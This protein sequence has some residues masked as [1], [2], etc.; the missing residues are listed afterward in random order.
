MV[1]KRRIY[2]WLLNQMQFK[3]SGCLHF[4]SNKLI[5]RGFLSVS[6]KVSSPTF[7]LSFFLLSEEF[8]DTCISRYFLIVQQNWDAQ[9]L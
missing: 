9:M 4:I 2:F 5:A 7:T 3:V 8:F 6:Y 1:L